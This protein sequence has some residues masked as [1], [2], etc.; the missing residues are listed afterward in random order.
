VSTVTG[1]GTLIDEVRLD[2]ARITEVVHAGGLMIPLH[3]HDAPKLVVL[4]AGGATERS[5]LDITEYR[6]GTLVIRDRVCVHEN[7]YH[8]GGARSL[9]IELDELPVATRRLSASVSLQLGQRMIAA[10]R[11]SHAERA[12]HLQHAIAAARE[13]LRAARPSA[14]PMWLERVRERLFEQLLSPPSLAELAREA[15]VHPVH[16]AQAFHARWNV[17]PHGY[18]RAH[19][20]FHATACIQRGDR[21]ADIAAEVGYADQSH[22]TRAIS[23]ARGAPPGALR[24]KIHEP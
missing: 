6:A 23:S 11:A 12:R 17:A 22:L 20:V 4:I 10:T 15:A 5:G 16:L 14:A 21:L 1:H 13:A 18:V 8:A 24:R 19:R 9:V 3:A 7:Q 2:G